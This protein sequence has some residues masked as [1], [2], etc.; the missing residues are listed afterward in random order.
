MVAAT[1]MGENVAAV[2]VA[3]AVAGTWRYV[4]TTRKMASTLI[5]AGGAVDPSGWHLKQL[6]PFSRWRCLSLTR[7]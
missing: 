2:V 3:V 6:P 7:Q 5:A 1:C 4:P